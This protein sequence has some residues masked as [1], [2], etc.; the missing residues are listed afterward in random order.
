MSTNIIVANILALNGTVAKLYPGIVVIPHAPITAIP[1][2]NM[3]LDITSKIPLYVIFPN[4]NTPLSWGYKKKPFIGNVFFLC[5][6]L[7]RNDG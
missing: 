4:H 3:K 2:M 1:V 7:R 5:N 6:Y